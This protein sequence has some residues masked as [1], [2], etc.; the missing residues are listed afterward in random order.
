MH[1]IAQKELSHKAKLSI[2]RS[3]YVLTA[4]YG[5]EVW[6][7]TERTRSQIQAA[8]VFSVATKVVLLA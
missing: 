8:S 1:L 4:A 3:V 7:V 2:N 5:H 6:V